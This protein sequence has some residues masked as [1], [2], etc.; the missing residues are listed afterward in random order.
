[1]ILCQDEP[2]GV[3]LDVQAEDDVAILRQYDSGLNYEPSD[4][5]V[6]PDVEMARKLAGWLIRWANQQ[7]AG[8]D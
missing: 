8:G 4:T 5:I 2:E 1:M 7:S 3:A 6:I